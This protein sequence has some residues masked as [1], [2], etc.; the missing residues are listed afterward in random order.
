MYAKALVNDEIVTRKSV[1]AINSGAEV[2]I[3]L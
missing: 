1:Y 2:I 3:P